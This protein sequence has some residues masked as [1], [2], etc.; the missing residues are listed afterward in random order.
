MESKF[1]T[2]AG[3][4][5]SSREMTPE[6]FMVAPATLAR[7]GI[8]RYTA[9]EL[10]LKGMD[11]NTIVTLYRPLDELTKSVPTFENNAMTVKH[12]PNYLVTADN[13]PDVSVGEVRD[14]K[15]VGDEMQA[16]VFIKA[17]KGLDAVASGTK[18]LSNGYK[19]DLDPT[20]GTTSEG[21]AYDGVQRNIR[22]NHVAIVD[23][24]RGGQVC[25]IA[26]HNTIEEGAAKKMKKVLVDG[27]SVEVGD[28]E[29]AIIERAESKRVEAVANLAKTVK[30]GSAVLAIGD[31]AAVQLAFDGLAAE[32]ATAKAAAVTPEQ[33]EARVKRR[34]VVIDSARRLMPAIVVDGKDD[35][36]IQREV[37]S[38]VSAADETTNAI[39]TAVLG[40]VALDAAKPE[41]VTVAFNAAVAGFKPASGASSAH[42]AGDA[43][44]A[45][46]LSGKSNETGTPVLVGRAA[47]LARQNQFHES[48]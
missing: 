44:L 39:I 27:L 28:T 9:G 37:I 30:V 38:H 20:P 43:A 40:G 31:A 29:A 22:G 45:T 1:A 24:P 19:F 8:H 10:S 34:V 11:E 41:G 35:T 42:V 18:F 16:R 46:A 2:D 14:V 15:M 47:F 4:A 48:K 33:V 13:W 17:R 6:G 36:T 12:P 32:L 7:T 26:D 25:R 23:L 5:L 21:V 3:V